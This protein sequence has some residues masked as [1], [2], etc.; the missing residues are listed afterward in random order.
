MT[1]FFIADMHFG[2]VSNA[3]S[4]KFVSSDAMDAAIIEAWRDRVAGEDVVWIL[5]DVGSLE[6]LRDLAGTKHLIFG[7]N[8]R[9]KGMFKDCGIFASCANSHTHRS[10]RGA[11][12]FI[13]RPE[14]APGDGLPV[15]HGHT[16]AGTDEVDPRFISVSV[17]KT[18]WGP[19]GFG[20]VWRRV[21]QRKV[22][23]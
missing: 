1:E 18:G 9:P 5:G 21:E 15:L 20:E 4:R 14:D 6:P 3:K 11:M 8:D 12:H 17:D 7:N 22:F 2:S 23:G 13:H 19:I 10:D 16:H